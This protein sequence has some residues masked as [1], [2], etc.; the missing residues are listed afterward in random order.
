MGS[1]DKSQGGSS[2][3]VSDVFFIQRDNLHPDNNPKQLPLSVSRERK[4]L[5]DALRKIDEKY[6]QARVDGE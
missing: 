1:L 3:R 4:L 5:D 2:K 6:R